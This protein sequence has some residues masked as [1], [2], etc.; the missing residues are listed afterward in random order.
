MKT[1]ILILA[2][3]SIL[4]SQYCEIGIILE[5]DPDYIHYLDEPC[6]VLISEVKIIPKDQ[7]IYDR[8]NYLYRKL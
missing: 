2:I 3:L 6:K 8:K 4:R 1:T 7:V 5:S